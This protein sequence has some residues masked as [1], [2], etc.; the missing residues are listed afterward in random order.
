MGTDV[1]EKILRAF[2]F[3]ILVSAS[4]RPCPQCSQEAMLPGLN[5]IS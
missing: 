4:V 3:T 1:A 2:R 5:R